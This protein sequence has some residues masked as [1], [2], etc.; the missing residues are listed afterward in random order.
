MSQTRLSNFAASIRL[1]AGLGF[2]V[3]CYATA[4]NAQVILQWDL[5][6]G[7]GSSTNTV[8]SSLVVGVSGSQMT[9]GGATGNNTSPSDT[10]NRTFGSFTGFG[11]AMSNTNYFSWTTTASANYA[12]YI[13]NFGGLNLRRTSS[14]PT[15][16][17]LFY[18]TNGTDFI[19]TGSSF[20]VLSNS[21]TSA[22]SSFGS[23]LATNPL[24]FSNGQI[25]YWRLVA[26]GGT[27]GRIG[28]GSAATNDVQILG[29][30]GPIYT[31]GTNNLTVADSLVAGISGTAVV[32]LSGSYS[33]IISMS[34]GTLNVSA[35]G[36]TITNYSGG[37]VSVSNGLTVEIRSGDSAGSIGGAG[38]L[39]KTGS[40][41]LILSGSNS[42]TG[43][44]TVSTGRLTVN[45]SLAGSATVTNAGTLAG[46]GTVG[47][48]SVAQGG[49]VS[50]G[51]NGAGTL[52]VSSNATLNPSGN[53]N[54]HLRDAAGAAGSGYDRIAVAGAVVLTN[55]NASNRFKI[56]LAT[57][58]GS[59]SSE[60]A[61]TATNFSKTNSYTWTILTASN[62]FT[63]SFNAAHFTVNTGPANGA[64]GFLNDFSGGYFALRTNSNSLVLVYTPFSATPAIT[65]PTTV[66]AVR[67]NTFTYQISASH[68]VTN[69]SASGLPAGWSINLTNGLLTAS[70][71]AAGT[72]TLTL[73]A[74]GAAG[75]AT[76]TVT[77]VFTEGITLSNSFSGTTPAT[78]GYNLAHF[79]TN[80]NGFDWFRASG[81]KA[82]RVFV[83]ATEIQ[84]TNSPSPGRS[85]VTNEATFWSTIGNARS[86]GTNST[87][88]IK[89]SDFSYDF[90]SFNGANDINYKFAFTQLR[91]L[92]V[93]ILVNVT[94]SPGRFPVTNTSDWSGMWELWQ[95][96]YAQA[97]VLA[98][99]YDIARFSMFNEPNVWTPSIT[100]SNWFQRLRVCSDAI[101]RAIADVNAI[102]GKSLVPR[103]YAPNTANGKEK[104]NSVEDTWGRDTIVNRY[105]QLSNVTTN[106]WTPRTNAIPWT[107][108][109]VYNYQK[110]AMF[111]H[112]S[113]GQTG[114]ATD[115]NDLKSY[116][117][118]DLGGEALPPIALTEY[119][120]RT[121]SSYD[122]RPENLDSPSDYIA[123]GAN[124][125]A[126]TENGANELYLFKFGQTDSGNTNYG[127]AKN[128]TH[129]VQNDTNS[130]FN[131]GG[132]TKAA[133]VYRFFNKAAQ[134]ARQRFA[135]RA[136]SG[137]ASSTTAG[138]WTLAARDATNGMVRVFFAN[139]ETNSNALSLDLSALGIP[140]GVPAVVEEVGTAASGQG[141]MA[142][143]VYGGR[144]GLGSIP[145]SG[146]WLV[147]VPTNTASLFL[148]SAEADAEL[149]DGTNSITANGASASMNARSDGTANGRRAVLI[150]VPVTGADI[151]NGRAF[152]LDLEVA[153]SSTN[154][155]AQAHVYGVDGSDAWNE[156]D[157]AWANCTFLRQGV[158]D[159]SQISAN[160]ALN[161]G[162]NAPCRYLG[163]LVA[164]SATPTRALVDVTD[165]VEGQTDGYATFLVL[166]DHRWDY[167]ADTLTNRTSGDIQSAGIVVTSRE[168]NDGAPRLVG[169]SVGPISAGPAIL[170]GPKDQQ[171]NTGDPLT[172]SVTADLSSP[173]SY[174]WF[175]NGEIVAGANGSTLVLSNVS[176]ADAGVYTVGVT[177]ANGTSVSSGGVVAVSGK[178]LASIALNSLVQAFDGSARNAT[179]T[180][181][182][183]S[184]PVDFTYNGLSSA[185][186][187]PGSYE[188]VGT[189][190]DASYQGAA[191]NTFIITGPLPVADA[192][193]KTNNTSTYK[194]PLSRLLTNDSRVIV[195]GTQITNSGLSVVGVTAGS[196]SSVSIQSA[197]VVFRPSTNSSDTFFYRVTDGPSTNTAMVTVSLSAN[198]NVTYLSLQVS[199]LGTA[200][201]DGL[202]TTMTNSFIG[203]PNKTYGVQ[204]KGEL[205]DPWS[206]ASPVN[207]GSGSFS[208]GF[209]RAGDYAADWNGSMFFRGY[210]TNTNQ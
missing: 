192:L 96:F 145:G 133:E 74:A 120:V 185:P 29:F 45:G 98:R 171:L 85:L 149:A 19:Q 201:Y 128:G 115:I 80:G 173:V 194:V 154:N 28:I 181:A 161:A 57:L 34:G 111:T 130:A 158:A 209:T 113:G 22:A 190:N 123:L 21:L 182:P 210:L 121:S 177:S 11:Q 42:Q 188:V 63:G 92:G 70:N 119:N 159:G 89:W 125:V 183:A 75:A 138:L 134:G 153:S 202:S 90:T 17:G 2:L 67:S 62:G 54:W 167:S 195:D 151:T 55:L 82:A 114:Y 175:K 193:T 65:S 6:N 129:Y 141:R 39:L 71:P 189:I 36:I 87:N 176:P 3:L 156:W 12:V 38:G 165:F 95:H 204:Y 198:T 150:K 73:I 50:P 147:T 37:S 52:T 97:Y 174:Q 148:L 47:G 13:T 27:G 81:V 143:N 88:F 178:T 1:V 7:T 68:A 18:S 180:T 102:H 207:S 66:S 112:D 169:V 35:L 107:L 58:S 24:V 59:S 23:T 33:K 100:E 103:I 142:G 200:V 61:G 14:G 184:L 155:S 69:F 108:S 8:G 56:N 101:Q 41:T 15:N 51:T 10:W 124:S 4:A 126:L 110:Y 16:A 197:F 140:D 20:E 160:V 53:Y 46:S 64:G 196:V 136:S 44:V 127:I 186:T 166:Q 116:I 32:N 79:T 199:E 157:T 83:S 105:L 25:V 144:V 5:N 72:N 208:V 77:F 26:F 48:M 131:Y 93:D 86:G 106:T 164:S 60:T 135:F 109:H 40:G 163:Q 170:A 152:Y 117:T 168:S 91:G 191:T 122:L 132:A 49:T 205:G 31:N 203:V 78:L 162:S 94:A 146:S 104:Y 76:N 118:N 137:A 172:L 43:A 99:D 206:T 30:T 187:N 84:P 139:K 9:G 179:A